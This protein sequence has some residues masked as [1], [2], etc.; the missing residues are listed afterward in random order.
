M[1]PFSFVAI[2]FLIPVILKSYLL[3]GFDLFCGVNTHLSFARPLLPFILAACG[4]FIFVLEGAQSSVILA[5]KQSAESLHHILDT[6]DISNRARQWATRALTK[7][8][9][10]AKIDNFIIGRQLLIIALAFLFKYSY[11][12]ASLNPMEIQ[13][14]AQAKISCIAR[15]EWVLSAYSVLD[16]WLFS[17][18]LCSVLVAYIFQVP[19]KLM[20]QSHPMRFLTTVP[21]SIQT[22]VISYKIGALS[23]LGR[24][25]DALR[26]RGA[27]R[28]TQQM[29]SYFHGK[30]SSP[31]STQQVFDALANLYGE[32]VKQIS[33]TLCPESPQKQ[34]VW[35]VEDASVYQ[36]VR[37]NCEFSQTIQVPQMSTFKYDVFAENPPGQNR[38]PPL[39]TNAN[40][41]SITPAAGGTSEVLSRVYAQFGS[42]QPIGSFVIWEMSYLTPVLKTPG[43]GGIPSKVFDIHVKKPV[44][45]VV[46]RVAGI[47]CVDPKVEI[48]PVDGAESPTCGAIE[49]ESATTTKGVVVHYPPIGSM[50]RFRF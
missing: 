17:T 4:Y 31:V 24:P 3:T 33:V 19:S 13:A 6:I 25:L 46:F 12:S 8:I 39:Q 11:D 49:K 36:I 5:N 29:F 40:Q 18:F 28:S 43:I 7:I 47:D 2:L 42:D 21:L 9:D 32:Y 15:P 1:K 30:E 23:Q 20:A 38:K 26:R 44:E 22:P 16:Y 35:F 45:K 27:L 41:Y 50:L 10:G 34:D 48:L 14:V 37:P